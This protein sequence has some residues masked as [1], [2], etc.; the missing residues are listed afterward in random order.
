MPSSPVVQSGVFQAL[1]KYKN[2]RQYLSTSSGILKTNMKV[3]HCDFYADMNSVYEKYTDYVTKVWITQRIKRD[4]SEK[5]GLVF[6]QFKRYMILYSIL[7][8]S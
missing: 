7:N 5:I 8:L 2:L 1:L 3:K 4:L 6:S